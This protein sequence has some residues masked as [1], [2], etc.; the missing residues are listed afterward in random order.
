M[1]R[2]DNLAVGVGDAF[3]LDEHG[4]LHLDA[5]AAVLGR[6]RC[7]GGQAA[8]GACP[9][10]VLAAI[11]AAVPAAVHGGGRRLTRLGGAPA[12]SSAVTA[13][14]AE[15]SAVTAPN[16]DDANFANVCEFFFTVRVWSFFYLK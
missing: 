10:A 12:E 15:T 4:L 11:L 1:G 16:D 6:R 7:L 13:P 8:A 3:F 9:A 2:S 5:A 14:N